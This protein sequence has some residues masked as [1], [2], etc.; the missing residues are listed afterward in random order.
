MGVTVSKSGEKDKRTSKTM[1]DFKRVSTRVG[2]IGV[3]ARQARLKSE[4]AKNRPD[5]GGTNVDDPLPSNDH[6]SEVTTDRAHELRRPSMAKFYDGDDT[7]HSLVYKDTADAWAALREGV[8][9]D[10]F[11][12]IPETEISVVESTLGGY[13]TVEK[14]RGAV[15]SNHHTSDGE[16]DSGNDSYRDNVKDYSSSR[17]DDF[18][19]PFADGV[20]PAGWKDK[21]S[22]KS[23]CT[24]CDTNSGHEVYSCR[25]CDLVFHED[26]LRRGGKLHDD[27]ALRSF[28]QASTNIGWACHECENLGQLLSDDEMFELMEIFERCDVDSDATIS[29]EEFTE[30][31]RVV[32]KEHEG[33]DLTMEE[34]EDEAR[35]FKSMDTDRTGN[36]SWWEFL[37]HEAIRRLANRPKRKLVMMLKP[38]EIQT[39]RSNFEMYDTDGDGCVTEYEARRA[40]KRWFSK[41]VEDPLDMSPSSQRRVGSQ[42]SLRMA[43]EFNS[44]VHTN[45]SLMMGADSDRSGSVSWEEYVMEQALYTLAVRPNIG[46]VKISRRP[47]F[48]SY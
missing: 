30:Y 16:F 22:S 35:N 28:R 24:I 15:G 33:R 36:L 25:I 31:R 32:V 20:E 40:F 4:A 48:C 26:C 17:E 5:G 14:T 2:K 1:Q 12:S 13:K 45:T 9:L 8:V 46:P 21:V 19:I 44:H 29:L 10:T 34:I 38:K 3:M 11:E 23:R 47:T 18:V 42:T 41:F 7:G 37:N 43:S 27:D 39:L 6:L